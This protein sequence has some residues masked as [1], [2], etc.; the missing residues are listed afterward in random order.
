MEDIRAI[1]RAADGLIAAGGRSLLTKILRG[2]RAKDVLSR[3]LD[4]NPA[5]GI[6]QKLA[7]EEVLA[8]IDWTIL[9]GYLRIIYDGRLPVLAYT[10]DGWDIERA[11]YAEEIIAGF[12][13]LL[14]SG[15]RPYEMGYLKDRNRELIFHVLEKLEALGDCKYV[16]VLED[17]ELVDYKKVREKI[18]SLIQYLNEPAG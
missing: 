3:S 16:P 10:H 1:L 6:Y 12:D 14:A 8:R 15:Q 7:E 13:R 17:W 11:T 9:H 5:Y 18:R 4:Q 2:S